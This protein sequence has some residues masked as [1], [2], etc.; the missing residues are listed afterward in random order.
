MMTFSSRYTDLH[1]QLRSV[2]FIALSRALQSLA[3]LLCV[4]TCHTSSVRLEFGLVQL[5]VVFFSTDNSCM[6]IR[7]IVIALA[8]L[9]SHHEK[10]IGTN[11]YYYTLQ[12]LQS[13]YKSLDQQ[14]MFWL[15]CQYPA[16]VF[17]FSISCENQKAVRHAYTEICHNE[18][19][20]SA[21][22]LYHLISALIGAIIQLC[23]PQYSSSVLFWTSLPLSSSV[24]SCQ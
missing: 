15:L 7:R 12:L 18:L 11:S 23:T 20:C 2:K 17:F 8:Y 22:L 5:C 21:Q 19:G 16:L 13:D 24:T 6:Q 4:F 10:I 9:V 3:Y 1:I 14:H